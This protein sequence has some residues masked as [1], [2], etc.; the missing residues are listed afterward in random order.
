MRRLA[1]F[2]VGLLLAACTGGEG[3]GTGGGAGGGSGGGGAPF[4]VDR[5]VETSSPQL[6]RDNAGTLH[7]LSAPGAADAQ[8]HSFVRYAECASGCDAAG[9]WTSLTVGDGAFSDAVKLAVEPGGAVHIAVFSKTQVTFGRCPQGCSSVASWAFSGIAPP[10]GQSWTNLPRGRAFAVSAS[11]EER[12]LLNGIAGAGPQLLLLARGAGGWTSNPLVDGEANAVSLLAAGDAA[13]L[14]ASPLNGPNQ[15][16]YAECGAGCG[17]VAAW[18]QAAVLAS[19]AYAVGLDRSPTGQLH[20]ATTSSSGSTDRLRY[21]QC[22]SQCL[23]PSS[24]TVVDLGDGADGR[25]GLDVSV[26]ASGA[27]AVAGGTVANEGQSLTLRR[28][29]GTCGQAASWSGGTLETGAAVHDAHPTYNG[30][31]CSESSTLR[32]WTVGEAVQLV[33][34]GSGWL[35]GYDAQSS[36]R[37]LA[38]TSTTS[39]VSGAWVRLQTQ[40]SP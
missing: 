40:P 31:A 30:A 27:V 35:L 3:G 15:L 10:N 34:T 12:L 13:Y 36:S 7:L 5:S 38:G 25:G 33:S 28:C 32:Y 6:A 18:S 9:G 29:A 4:L 2:S 20:V 11:G 16:T 19:N 26:L 24:W 23:A 22:A 21:A 14:V 1:T 17:A 8:G 37:C 39:F